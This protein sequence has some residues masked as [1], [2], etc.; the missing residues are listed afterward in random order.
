[1]DAMSKD[2]DVT[3]EGPMDDLLGIEV[4]R[5]DDGSI[6]LH[7]RAYI[8]KITDEHLPDGPLSKAQRN[9]VPYSK[10]FLVNITEALLHDASPHARA[11]AV[12]PRKGRRSHQ[13]LHQLSSYG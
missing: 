12:P 10:D 5:L 4:D 9:S 1:M 2:W 6:K 3:D 11:R 7:Q 8:K 13:T